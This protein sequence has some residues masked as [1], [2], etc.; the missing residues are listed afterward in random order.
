MLDISKELKHF[1]RPH[2]NSVIETV[3]DILNKLKNENCEIYLVYYEETKTKPSYIGLAINEEETYVILQSPISMKD[4]SNLVTFFSVND[5]LIATKY[6]HRWL[7]KGIK[8]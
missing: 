1:N 2:L 4:Y 3:C 7:L 5:M 6:P 8:E